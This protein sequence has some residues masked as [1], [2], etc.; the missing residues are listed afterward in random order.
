MSVNKNSDIDQALQDRLSSTSNI[1]TDTNSRRRALNRAL[2]E[3]QL[4]ANW[5]WTI[6][7]TTFDYDAD[8]EE[9]SMATLGIT[10]F[11]DVYTVDGQSLYEANRLEQGIAKK[12]VNGV[13]VLMMDLSITT[14]EDV[15]F[16]YFSTSMVKDNDGSTL[17]EFF[18]N[19]DDTFLGPNEVI[20]LLIEWALVELFRDIKKID[21]ETIASAER[22]L[23]DLKIGAYKN[24][25]YAISKGK[26]IINI[27]R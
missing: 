14:T 4:F 21:K 17:K 7:E 27:A 26:K 22:R 5:M 2:S 25:G 6:K 12:M 3:I 19:A 8:T 15:D 13:Y 9:Y 16:G 24:F 11:K 23:E 10:D 1:K 20:P 18:I